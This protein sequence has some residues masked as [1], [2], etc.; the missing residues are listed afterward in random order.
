[1]VHNISMM[2]RD[3]GKL[4]KG[5]GCILV[6]TGVSDWAGNIL[7]LTQGIHTY[8]GVERWDSSCIAQN[9]V[10]TTSQ[11]RRPICRINICALNFSHVIN[12]SERGPVHQGEH[13]KTQMQKK[14]SIKMPYQES[15]CTCDFNKNRQSLAELGPRT[16]KTVQTMKSGIQ[17][18]LSSSFESLQVQIK[19]LAQTT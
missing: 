3:E 16:R 19:L 13:D 17:I 8:S 2:V 12:T 1:M 4:T 6:L 7:E 5:I 15:N 11:H 14:T 10:F 9:T 18:C